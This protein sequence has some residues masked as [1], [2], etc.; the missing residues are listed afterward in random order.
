M[1]NVMRRR[2]AAVLGVALC[3]ACAPGSCKG[4]RGSAGGQDE[5]G[6]AERR[7]TAQIQ[8][9]QALAARALTADERKVV[10]TT[11]FAILGGG[12]VKSFPLGYVALF[13]AQQPVYVTA[14]ALLHAWH[15]SYD[16]I[17]ERLEERSLIPMLDGM[18]GDLRRALAGHAGP[19]EVRADVDL[20]LAVAEGLLHDQAA[21]PVAG[22]DPQA[23]AAVIDRV[24][25]AKPGELALFGTAG[26]FDFSM[27]QPRG[28][29]ADPP[30][31]S[32]FRAMAWLGL[33]EL[34]I[35]HQAGR[36]QWTVNRRALQGALLVASLFDAGTR[37]TFDALDRTLAAFVGPP[38]SMSL[39]GLA[40]AR[41][42]LPADLAHASDD[43]IAAAFAGP[44]AQRIQTAAHPAD[45]ASIAFVLLG[46]RYV[47]D[48][49]V[50]SNLVYK[51]LATEPMRLMPSPLDVA[52]AVFGNP[53]AKRLLAPELT[54]YGARYADALDREHRAADAQ[55]G[56]LGTA[57]LYHHWLDA[58]RALSP[59]PA[60]DASL[61]APLTGDAWSRR[62]LN[63]QLA[64]WAELRHD[65]ILY[66]KQSGISVSC[67]YPDG[68]IDPYP[69]FYRAMEAIA[70]HGSAT[71]AALAAVHPPD[72][73][74]APYFESMRQ[75]MAR[76]GHIAERE[77]ANQ[78]LEPADLDFLNHMV[79]IDGKTVGC[80]T[81]DEAS[82]W[83]G[84]LF[85][86]RERALRHE[87]VIADVHTQATDA[88][89]DVVGRVLHVATAHPRMFVVAIAHDGGAH[90]QTYRGVVST[91]SELV[92][93]DFH[94]MTDQEWARDL[95]ERPPVMPPWL[96][97]I[98]AP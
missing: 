90:A 17:L 41:T 43:Q 63:T 95:A 9:E 80:E 21:P 54:R 38:D 3:M 76:L 59:D 25:G 5:Q 28:H 10:D 27:L 61:P 34:P 23:I 98:V 16:A 86:D 2:F 46:Q 78:P 87:M 6:R 57:S 4:R 11:R 64:S 93:T 72:P 8:D 18:L 45:E 48:S 92:T 13:H 53:A 44:A 55:L 22:A 71:V 50:M 33:V 19:P 52:Y 30:L 67:E 51:A 70:V 20:Y 75:T 39:S 60:R 97:D 49:H 1:A 62:M 24:R 69:A 7:G 65:N 26:A 91:Y 15:R 14:D 94:R 42:A 56:A 79:S 81:V 37:A 68:Y 35:A 66:A 58:L 96:A 85:F 73:Q 31:S 29:Y 36:G 40:A 47:L 88:S 74:L 82:G 12:P 32:Y 89:G 77:R 83:Y 84:E